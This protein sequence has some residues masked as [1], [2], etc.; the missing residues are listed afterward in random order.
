[1]NVANVKKIGERDFSFHHRSYSRPSNT[2]TTKN[3]PRTKMDKRVEFM[4]LTSNIESHDIVECIYVDENIP[5]PT[6]LPTKLPVVEDTRVPR[7]NKRITQP[8][9][10]E[11]HKFDSL[12]EFV[13]HFNT[14]KYEEWWFDDLY[15]AVF[16]ELG[17]KYPDQVLKVDFDD[18]IPEGIVVVDRAI[19]RL[20]A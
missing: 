13:E 15:Q 7:S 11:D 20:S 17:E 18:G 2:S 19:R 10:D 6:P 14:L 16:K 5:W 9:Y 3:Q 1:M 8:Q 4:T 12:E